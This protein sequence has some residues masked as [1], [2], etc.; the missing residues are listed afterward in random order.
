MSKP[1][2]VCG[3]RVHLSNFL[4]LMGNVT[5]SPTCHAV[6]RA[7]LQAVRRAKASVAKS[8]QDLT[9]QP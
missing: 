9:R 7:F 3:K 4:R 1:C 8:V 6:H 5:C 2:C